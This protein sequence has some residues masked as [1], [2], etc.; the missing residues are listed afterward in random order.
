LYAG[1]NGYLDKLNNAQIA[2]FE[3]ALFSFLDSSVFFKPY[4]YL[5]ADS[6]DKEILEFI[7][8]VFISQLEQK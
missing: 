8:S 2:S 5:I 1:F 7:L 4:K 6:L 3:D